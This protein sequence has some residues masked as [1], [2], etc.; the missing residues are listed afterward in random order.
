MA[1]GV[2]IGDLV[3]ILQGCMKLY[4]KIN[5]AGEVIDDVQDR[6]QEILGWIKPIQAHL[7]DKYGPARNYAE[8]PTIQ[9]IVDKMKVEATSIREIFQRFREADRDDDIWG[10]ARRIRFA[11]GSST[12]ELENL[13]T[14]IERR[15]DNLD[16][17]VRLMDSKHLQKQVRQAQ[18]PL[19]GTCKRRNVKILFVDPANVGRSMVAQGY[20]QLVRE[21]TTRLKK[22][23]FIVAIHSAGIH[24][25]NT[26]PNGL[27]ELQDELKL[28]SVEADQAPRAVAQSALFENKYFNY[29][30]KTTIAERLSK[31]RSRGLSRTT[32]K[33]YDYIFVFRFK[34]NIALQ[35]LKAKTKKAYGAQ[36]VSKDKG[37]IVMLGE[38]RN[39]NSCEISGPK[40]PKGSTGPSREDW[41]KCMG[42]IKTGFK[43]WLKDE[44]DWE[45]PW[46]HAAKTKQAP[47]PT[48]PSSPSPRVI[49]R[50]P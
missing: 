16:R 19:R 25:R 47:A 42:M 50:A 11:V 39:Q 34:D 21:A 13:I 5:D 44:L 8:A 33:D 2:G 35:K 29:D 20:A 32:F 41:D 24:V 10:F 31:Q 27:A 4:N 37:K 7:H 30:Y 14:T 15:A 9:A 17:Q 43:G 36:F 26:G 18:K 38:Y 3:L 1:F 40:T 6:L 49:E 45:E 12:K 28:P 23:W 22:P 46:I 48:A